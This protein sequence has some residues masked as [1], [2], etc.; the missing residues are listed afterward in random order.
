MKMG[1][2]EGGER[3]ED[4]L[5]S[6]AARLLGQGAA[7][8]GSTRPATGTAQGNQERY[9]IETHQRCYTSQAQ[10]CRSQA[11]TMSFNIYGRAWEHGRSAISSSFA[12]ILNMPSQKFISFIGLSSITCILLEQ[13]GQGERQ[14]STIINQGF[15]T[16]QKKDMNTG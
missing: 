3:G 12:A 4:P 15:M 5:E 16:L 7:A 14:G 6:S 2:A 1:V 8:P 13:D 10:T 9:T 11:Q